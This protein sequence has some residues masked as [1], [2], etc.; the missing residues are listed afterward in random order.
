M[1]FWKLRK[2]PENFVEVRL[3]AYIQEMT[4]LQRSTSWIGTMIWFW[5]SWSLPTSTWIQA[6]IKQKRWI[7]RDKVI[8][9]TPGGHYL[10]LN[11]FG[12]NVAAIAE[13]DEAEVTADNLISAQPFSCS[14]YCHELSYATLITTSANVKCFYYIY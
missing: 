4:S 6:E 10:T 1:I 11:V 14:Y 12:Q 5:D 2:R 3:V 8:I 9:S 7:A 13:I